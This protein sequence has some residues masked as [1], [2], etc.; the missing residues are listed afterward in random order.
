LAFDTRFG[1]VQHLLLNVHEHQL[2]SSQRPRQAGL[3]NPG[4][5]PSSRLKL[6]SAQKT[7]FVQ[8]RPMH[9]LSIVAINESLD[10]LAHEIG[11]VDKHA[12]TDDCRRDRRSKDCVAR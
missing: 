8:R 10:A 11:R 7:R 3:K 1:H 9:E 5:G 12:P 4:P 6:T 2:S